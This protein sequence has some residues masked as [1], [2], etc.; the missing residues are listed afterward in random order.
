[1]TTHSQVR[2]GNSEMDEWR[3]RRYSERY[4]VKPGF[5]TSQPPAM[6]K[7][8]IPKVEKGGGNECQE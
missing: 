4:E 7:T 8:P 2:H 3:A 1:M 6:R 5:A